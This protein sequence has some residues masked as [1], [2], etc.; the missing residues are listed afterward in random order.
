MTNVT[1]KEKL[2]EIQ[3]ALLEQLQAVTSCVT[4]WFDFGDKQRANEAVQLLHQ[5]EC[6]LLLCRATDLSSL[7]QSVKLRLEQSVLNNQKDNDFAMAEALLILAQQ[8]DLSLMSPSKTQLQQAQQALLA[9]HDTAKTASVVTERVV[10]AVNQS[11]RES[12]AFAVKKGLA[13]MQQFFETQLFT[14]DTAADWLAA[15]KRLAAD[16]H[17]IAA[18]FHVADFALGRSL[19]EKMDALLSTDFDANDTA[20]KAHFITQFSEITT[21]LADALRYFQQEQLA[22]EVT[23]TA[24]AETDLS[25]YSRSLTFQRACLAAA[26]TLYRYIKQMRQATVLS[27]ADLSAAELMTLAGDIYPLKVTMQVLQVRSISRLLQELESVYLF[28]SANPSRTDNATTA[29]AELLALYEVLAQ[30]LSTDW[31]IDE[32]A[33]ALLQQAQQHFMQAI[34]FD[35]EKMAEADYQSDDEMPLDDRAEWDFDTAE[36]SSAE[37][38]LAANS[39]V[40]EVAE[41]VEQAIAQ[42]APA[43]TPT[44]DMGIL[45]AAGLAAGEKPSMS[46][47]AAA[48]TVETS[49]AVSGKPDGSQAALNSQ[50]ILGQLA[51]HSALSEPTA[52]LAADLAKDAEATEWA[53]GEDSVRTRIADLGQQSLTQAATADE[54]AYSEPFRTDGELFNVFTAEA[55]DIIQSSRENLKTWQEDTDNLAAIQAM[56]RSMHTLK[57]GANMTD[58]NVLGTLAHHLEALL[59]GLTEKTIDDS[60][61]AELMLQKGL[62]ASSHMLD[63]AS[64]RQRVY[65]DDL[66]LSQ[67]NDF[68]LTE[69]GHGLTSKAKNTPKTSRKQASVI[70]PKTE[71]TATTAHYW[72]R[73]QS[74]VINQ[75]SQLVGDD[76]IT[77]ARIERITAKHDF[78]IS[79]LS[80]TVQRVSEQ[81]RDLET[82]AETQLR[83]GYSEKVTEH[84]VIDGEVFDPLEMDR[85]SE[86]QQLS[87][88]LSESMEDLHSI[89]AS[90]KSSAQHM[91]QRLIEQGHVQRTLQDNILSI[92]LVRFDSMTE[93]LEQMIERLLQN[94]GKSVELKII[95]GEVE[96]ERQMLEEMVTRF[97]HIIRNAI[98]HGIE[99]PKKR[100]KLNKPPHGTIMLTVRR[101]GTETV[102]VIADDGKG[103]DLAAIREKAE[104]LGIG[105]AAELADENYLLQL[106]F[107]AGFSTLSRANQAAG[108]G[109]GLEI[110]HNAI[111][112]RQGSLV[113][114]SA[115]N[116]GLAL[117]IRLP[118]LVSVTDALVV[119][120]GRY[121]Y[122]VPMTSI[123]AV[124]R[125]PIDLYD[126]FT[127]GQSCSY[128]YGE[129]DYQIESLLDFMDP[130]AVYEPSAYG[131][132]VLLVNIDGQHV[133]LIIE[134]FDKRQE[135]VVNPVNRGFI[136]LPGVIGAAIL[137]N[138]L[139]VPVLEITTLGRYFLAVKKSGMDI[140][141]MLRNPIDN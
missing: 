97:E 16:F 6:A 131:M 45:P 130:S 95:G 117:T 4:D 87:H 74:K 46:E 24:V 141:Q 33:L 57:G 10:F 7:T 29:Y 63:M 89:H 40:S 25:A 61:Q 26:T 9:D 75:L 59:N 98:V 27:F 53:L 2:P 132:P 85:F 112:T 44:N 116:K 124:A 103:F 31:V 48:E 118:F 20:A 79:E 120:V 106:P 134:A 76:M 5:L 92:T 22:A 41:A 18:T 50:H 133:A 128:R 83:S 140:Q 14:A 125:L 47:L 62:T 137:D 99:S 43:K 80:R 70:E 58:F 129:H 119:Q 86:L 35:A 32:R 78:Q 34:D 101:E 21:Q 123:Q 8:T 52:E 127:A 105:S 107:S 17:W 104:K 139:P 84:I 111:V 12:I 102:F 135:L 68:L 42:A 91:K 110:L 15:G 72:L 100:K 90:L 37:N 60:E 67:L 122:A 109:I 114:E 11:T 64:E 39:S 19:C 108:R 121:T 126:K 138:G 51:G 115:A 56:K 82:E 65:T 81:L 88:L 1:C 36:H 49:T 55:K 3:P 71:E 136:A 66:Y 73:I 94:S 113:A 77:R 54:R 13:E 28:L 38:E 30:D 69:T 93:R 23:D 96:V